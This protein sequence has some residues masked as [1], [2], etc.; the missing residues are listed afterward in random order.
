MMATADYIVA[1]KDVLRHKYFLSGSSWEYDG[2]YNTHAGDNM[3]YHPNQPLIWSSFDILNE[4]GTVFLAASSPVPVL[5]IDHTAMVQGWIVGKRLAA[6]RGKNPVDIT[7]AVV[8]DGELYIINANA[9]LN[10]V[11]LEVF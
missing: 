9:M 11:E 6:M 4:E 10:D 5:S 2:L 3:T 8:V 7:D 1:V